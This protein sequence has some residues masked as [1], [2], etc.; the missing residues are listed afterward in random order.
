MMYLPIAI[1]RARDMG[2]NWFASVALSVVA[3]ALFL[4][5]L[6]MLLGIAK[7]K[8]TIDKLNSTKVFLIGIAAFFAIM[9]VIIVVAITLIYK[10]SWGSQ[11]DQRGLT[12]CDHWLRAKLRSHDSTPN[13]H[14]TNEAIE[15]IQA[16]N[17]DQCP[18]GTWNPVV[19]DLGRD[20]LGNID[21]KFRITNTNLRGTAVTLPADG[22][23]R[24]V[25]LAEKRQ[26]YSSK[27]DDPSVLTTPPTA[28]NQSTPTTT[29]ARPNYTSLLSTTSAATVRQALPTPTTDPRSGKETNIVNQEHFTEPELTAFENGRELFYQGRYEQAIKEF[30][31]AQEIRLAVPSPTLEA[32][33]GYMY[34]ALGDHE[35]S[36]EH[37]T[38]AIEIEDSASHRVGRA[39]SYIETGQWHLASRDAKAALEMEAAQTEGIH[40]HAEAYTILAIWYSLQKEYSLTNDHAS[41]ALDIMKTMKYNAPAQA[42]VH[43][44]KGKAQAALGNLE[45]AVESYSEAI[46]YDDNAQ[47]QSLRA[48]AYLAGNQCPEA[49]TDANAALMME[50][51]HEVGYHSDADAKTVLGVCSYQDGDLTSAEQ[52]LAEALAIMQGTEYQVEETQYWTELLTKIRQETGR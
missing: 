41:K 2:Y 11:P 31:K 7:S 46:I 8:T 40:M 48:Q 42:S 25:Y 43:K 37:Y 15:T 30:K 5:L 33:I 49:T 52:H 50:P 18:P 13:T 17:P 9:A 32:W 14:A 23:P 16:W 51:V 38:N 4:P 36:I 6:L 3:G 47:L 34:K 12:A 20:H 10:P 45:Q 28:S 21:V 44:L 35:Q 24:W 29:T 22:T 1:L 39:Q 19:N 26:W 27:L